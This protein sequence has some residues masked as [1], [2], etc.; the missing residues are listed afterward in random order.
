MKKENI[1]KA[2]ANAKAEYAELGVNTAGYM[3][4]NFIKIQ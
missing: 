2:Y 1:E 4:K 3:Q